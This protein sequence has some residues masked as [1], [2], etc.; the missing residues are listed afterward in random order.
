MCHTP[1]NQN[2][3]GGEILRIHQVLL[4]HDLAQHVA[5][6]GPTR[7]RK[8]QKQTHLA[9]ASVSRSANCGLAAGAHCCLYWRLCKLLF[10][11]L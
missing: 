2:Q 10:T 9:P 4:P 5:L 3:Q 1:G 7:E 6:Q 11:L 8:K